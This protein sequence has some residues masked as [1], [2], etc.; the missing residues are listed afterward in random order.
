MPWGSQKTE[1]KKEKKKRK[2]RNRG[3]RSRLGRK[4]QRETHSELKGHRAAQLD[5]VGA[6]PWEQAELRAEK[7]KKF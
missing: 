7:D 4:N 2:E 6:C 1:K 3:R 5:Q